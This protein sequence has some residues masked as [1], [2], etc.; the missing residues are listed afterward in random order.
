[1]KRKFGEKKK[2]KKRGKWVVDTLLEC[3]DL[4]EFLILLP[5]RILISTIRFIINLLNF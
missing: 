3:I 4:I 1:M 2:R 5:I